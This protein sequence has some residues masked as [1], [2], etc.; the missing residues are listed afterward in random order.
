M[1]ILRQRVGDGVKGRQGHTVL[2]LYSPREQFPPLGSS[3]SESE[4][5]GSHFCAVAYAPVSYSLVRGQHGGRCRSSEGEASACGMSD[6]SQTGFLGCRLEECGPQECASYCGHDPH[7]CDQCQKDH[8]TS[9]PH[10]HY[11]ADDLKEDAEE[12]RT[13]FSEAYCASDSPPSRWKDGK[14]GCAMVSHSIDNAGQ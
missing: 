2:L 14:P 7:G 9:C 10:T 13:T 6:C 4:R 12:A 11:D 1:N 3:T 5:L 8:E